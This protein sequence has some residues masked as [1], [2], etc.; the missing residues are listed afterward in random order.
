[1]LLEFHLRVRGLLLMSEA[2]IQHGVISFPTYRVIE[3]LYMYM[4]VIHPKSCSPAVV[5]SLPRILL[6]KW[7]MI[8][9][10]P[11]HN[12]PNRSII[13]TPILSFQPKPPRERDNDPAL[14]RISK[15]SKDY[16]FS[17]SPR[18]HYITR[19]IISCL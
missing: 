13:H 6:P 18:P 15:I 11:L 9:N 17:S 8:F 1:M 3:R 7:E 5:Q 4:G 10:F 16:L 12:Y 2:V 19:S 14:K